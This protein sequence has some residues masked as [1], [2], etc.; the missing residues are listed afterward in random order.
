MKGVKKG[1]RVFK[2]TME[3]VD[4]VEEYMKK[5]KGFEQKVKE[6]LKEVNAY[7]WTVYDKEKEEYVEEGKNR[8]MRA[9]AIFLV[10]VKICP[11][12]E[13]ENGSLGKYLKANIDVVGAR[14][15]H[16]AVTLD[17]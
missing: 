13:R 10:K 9:A 6:A 14:I 8:A 11:S 12:W 15:C 5:D 1:E 2:N 16:W 4:V 17:L 7:L 3:W